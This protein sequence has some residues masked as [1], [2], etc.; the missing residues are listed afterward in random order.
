M[1]IEKYINWFD[2]VI[3]LFIKPV[4]QFNF[5]RPKVNYFFNILKNSFIIS[6][7]YTSICIVKNHIFNKKQLINI[8]QRKV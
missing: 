8:L 6:F 7:L 5:P 3:I 4:Y 2:F 1:S